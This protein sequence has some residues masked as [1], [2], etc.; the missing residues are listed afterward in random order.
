[1]AYQDEESEEPVTLGYDQSKKLY[2]ELKEKNYIDHKDKATSTLKEDLESYAVDIPGEFKPWQ[3]A[4]LMELKRIT[5]RLPIKDGTKKKKVKLNKAI[6]NSQEFLDLW[7]KIKYK[8][9]YSIDFDSSELIQNAVNSIQKMNK[10]D[11]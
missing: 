1:L 5:E 11:K 10:I 7:D 8:T 3:S 4:I 2:Q 9:V 6:F